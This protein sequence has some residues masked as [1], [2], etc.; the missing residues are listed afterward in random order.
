MVKT[1]IYNLI[2]YTIIGFL[3]VSTILPIIAMILFIFSKG[4]SRINYEF[5]FTVSS[6]METGGIFAP[7]YGTIFL[8]FITMLIAVPIGV[9]SATYMSEY[10]KKGKLFY[11]LE[12]TIVNLAGIPSVVYGLFGL[13]IFVL[14]LKIGISILAGA[15][16]M[17]VLILPLIITVSYQ[18]LQAV[19]ENIREASYALG[20]SRLQTVVKVILPT[21]TPGILTGIILATA[22]V[23]GE[24]APILFTA[25]A[26]YLP[27][28][29]SSVF[30]KTMLLSYHLFAISTQVVGVSDEQKY[31]VT[32]VLISVVLILNL[33][34]ILIRDKISKKLGVHK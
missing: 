21:A 10:T 8:T 20:A 9:M 2:G 19:S 1:K 23:A 31:G 27:S 33:L 4:I 28:L 15:L 13:G 34:A 12:L 24:T 25:A 22:R 32:F 7:I 14:L 16:T 26:Y 17:G 18:S 30:D 5:L 29:P 11:L 3:C 6:S